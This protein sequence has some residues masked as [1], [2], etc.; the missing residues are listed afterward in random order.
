MKRL[1]LFAALF[2]AGYSQAQDLAFARQMVDT[3]TSPTFWGRG[4]TNDGMKKAGD[5]I[6]AQFQSYGLKPMDGKNFQQEFS[7]PVNTFP[8]KMEVMING[9]QL[10]PGK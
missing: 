6:A 2:V 5:F 10:V 8:G 7:Y 1:L 9:K 4:Y 3:L